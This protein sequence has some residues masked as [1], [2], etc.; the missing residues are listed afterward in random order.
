MD[1]SSCRRMA[2]T[3]TAAICLSF[4]VLAVQSVPSAANP[5]DIGSASSCVSVFSPI[6]M[7]FVDYLVPEPIANLTDAIDAFIE[8]Q[9]DNADPDDGDCAEGLLEALCNEQYPRCNQSDRTVSAQLAVNCTQRLGTCTVLRSFL[10]DKYCN[11]EISNASLDQ[12]KTISQLS[13]ESGYV[14]SR[15]SSL[16]SWGEDYMTEW[17]FSYLTEIDKSVDEFLSGRGISEQCKLDYISFRCG[18]VGRCWDNGNRI[19]LTQNQADCF[20]ARTPE[21]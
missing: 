2:Y 1:L 21:W 10:I 9:H 13:E 7:D 14:F 19:E 12:C 5:L 18:S 6:C 20:A 4:V 3:I 11:F 8:I 16:P 15:C 17:M